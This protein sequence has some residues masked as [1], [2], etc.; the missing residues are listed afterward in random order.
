MTDMLYA[1]WGLVATPLSY[2]FMRGR[3]WSRC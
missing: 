2:G 3:C 1:L